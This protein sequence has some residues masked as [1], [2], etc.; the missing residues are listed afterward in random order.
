V[1]KSIDIQKVVS[2][3][4]APLIYN[5]GDFTAIQKKSSLPFLKALQE[6]EERMMK[7]NQKYYNE[8]RDLFTTAFP[9]KNI[10]RDYL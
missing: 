10:F 4:I 2:I 6:N 8:F 3:F 1:R 7:M 9:E 5:K